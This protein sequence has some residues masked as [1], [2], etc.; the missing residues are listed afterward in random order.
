MRLEEKEKT[1]ELS[2]EDT[3]CGIPGEVGER[4]FERFYQSKHSE[5]SLKAGFGIGLFLAKTFVEAHKGQLDYTTKLEQGTT[6]CISLLKGQEH[7]ETTQIYPVGTRK[8]GMLEELNVQEETPIPE[9][10]GT[11]LLLQ[12]D[13]SM[14]T[15]ITGGHTMLL[16]DDNEEIRA[17]LRQVFKDSFTLFEAGNG[18]EGLAMAIQHMPDI[19]ISDIVMNEMTGIEF[20]KAIKEDPALSH[21]QLILLTGS[22][23]AE[24]KLKGVECGADDYITKP[25]E[26]DLLLARVSNLL[27]SRNNLQKY[28]YNEITLRKND[29]SISEDY[30]VFLEKC[31]ETVEEHID[32]DDFSIKFFAKEMGMS[33]SNLYKRVKQVSGQSISSF[34]RFIRLRK[35]AGLLISTDCNVNEAAFQVGIA[36]SKYFRLQFAKLFGMNPSEYKKRYHQAF[37]K[38]YTVHVKAVKARPAL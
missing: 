30:K 31:I 15:L 33:H 36:D 28:F 12:R 1:I 16:V 9:A 20:C 6:F 14:D 24:I 19:I 29:L 35:A 13:T 26:R 10:H 5:S 7:F 21:I 27:K 23:S 2:V 18:K 17:Y 37:Q 38:S 4:L 34:I 8:S 3:G 25:F 32:R 11:D 22:S